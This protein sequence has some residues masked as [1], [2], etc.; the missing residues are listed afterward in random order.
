MT[1]FSAGFESLLSFPLGIAVNVCGSLYLTLPLFCALMQLIKLLS[2][3]PV[4][5][6]PLEGSLTRL[7]QEVS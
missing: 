4:L 1:V 3:I 5:A 6:S 2:I 7:E